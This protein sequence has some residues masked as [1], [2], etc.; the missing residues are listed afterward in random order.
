MFPSILKRALPLHVAQHSLQ[1]KSR[2]KIL[3]IPN[4]IFF[5][6]CIE[7][8]NFS[9]TFA[10]ESDTVIRFHQSK[11]NLSPKDTVR[12]FLPVTTQWVFDNA[13]CTQVPPFS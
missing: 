2:S 13:F 10:A 11:E 3:T 12:L 4:L 8:E 5:V 6:N 9:S 1:L 7:E